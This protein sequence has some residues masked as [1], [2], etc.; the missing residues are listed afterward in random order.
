MAI[1]R[2]SSDERGDG[3]LVNLGKV[4]IGTTSPSYTLE[5]S[6]ATAAASTTSARLVDSAAA[7]GESVNYL[8]V[9]KGAGYGGALGGYLSQ[10]VGSGL[11]FS[12]LNSATLTERMRIDSSGLV[13]I[14]TSSPSEKLSVLDG[15]F[16]ISK[17]SYGGL[18]KWTQGTTSPRAGYWEWGD[19]T[20]WRMDFGPS[21]TP[22]F[23][24]MDNG[25]VGIGTGTTN[26]SSTLDVKGTLRLSGSTSGYVGF[27]PAAAAGSTTYTL[28]A[29]DGTASQVLSTNGSG[30][31]S[32]IAN[33]GGA[34]ATLSATNA[35][36][37]VNSFAIKTTMAR[38]TGASVGAGPY[39]FDYNNTGTITLQDSLAPGYVA[40]NVDSSSTNF[41]PTNDNF[42]LVN[43]YGS[44]W[45]GIGFHS[46]VATEVQ[47]V[48]G[49][50]SMTSYT[51]WQNTNA[52][53]VGYLNNGPR[54]LFSDFD[55]ETSQSNTI[56]L[57]AEQIVLGSTTGGGIVHAYIPTIAD[58]ATT[59]DHKYGYVLLGGTTAYTITLPSA[60][61]RIGRWYSFK[62]ITVTNVVTITAAAGQTI[63]GASSVTISAQYA[64]LTLLAC[65]S[66]EW[67]TV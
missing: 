31:L 9:E 44:K 24:I 17:T 2:L 62:K 56:R 63:D 41:W 34:G 38:M 33:G 11:I 8:R 39:P 20:G 55:L 3:T 59:L 48:S 61:T 65:S 10:G 46:G 22:R 49:S 4:G 14:G 29:A 66:T 13:G 50:L 5:V 37:G 25:N 40:N 67:F 23:S 36:T 64:K 57:V 16:L 51:K 54:A 27:S 60:A 45:T 26:P 47:R 58:V 52:M 12:T 19:G 21:A 43:T 28:P 7:T 15:N 42:A 1:K 35:W 30:V 18:L 32:W 6:L 53:I